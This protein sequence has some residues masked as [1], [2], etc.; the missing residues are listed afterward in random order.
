M[1]LKT[2]TRQATYINTNTNTYKQINKQIIK[3]I[4]SHAFVKT[5]VINLL[6]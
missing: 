3:S 5:D 2:K 6:I 4:A 1:K